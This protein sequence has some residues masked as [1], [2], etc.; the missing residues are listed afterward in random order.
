MYIWYPMIDLIHVIILGMIAAMAVAVPLGMMLG[1]LL[2][3]APPKW[4]DICEWIWLDLKNTIAW[5]F[6]P[7]TWMWR[8]IARG[9]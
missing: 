3:K 1:R 9:R 7:V 8:R 6:F 4:S 2:T 5:Y